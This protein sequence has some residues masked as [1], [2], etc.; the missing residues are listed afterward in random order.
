MFRS[1]S[2]HLADGVRKKYSNSKSYLITETQLRFIHVPKFF[3]RTIEGLHDQ[4]SRLS[5]I[6]ADTN[7]VTPKHLL[8]TLFTLVQKGYIDCSGR[9]LPSVLKGT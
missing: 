9:P 2:I 6:Y 1:L 8:Q 4:G 7:Q 3:Y 5:E